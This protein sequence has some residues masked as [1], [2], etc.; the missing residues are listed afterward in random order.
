MANQAHKQLDEDIQLFGVDEYR[1]MLQECDDSGFHYQIGLNGHLK[2]DVDE[3]QDT[4]DLWPMFHILHSLLDRP[5]LKSILR[6][7]GRV[8]LPRPKPD[9]SQYVYRQ[10]EI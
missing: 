6:E 9:F 2:V 3:N 1:I 7:A 8:E 10:I 5:L 4:N